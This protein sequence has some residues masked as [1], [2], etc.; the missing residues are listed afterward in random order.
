MTA[1]AAIEVRGLGKRRGGRWVVD[2]VSFTVAAGEVVALA[3]GNGAG[4]TTVLAMIAGVLEP[5]R[6][7]IALAGEPAHRRRRLGYV[8]EAADPPGHLTGAELL[9]LCAALRG[10]PPLDDEAARLLDVAAVAPRR[11]DRMSLG[12]RRRACLAAALIGAPPALVLDE[13]DNGLDAAGLDALATVVAHARERGAGVLVATHDPTIKDRLAG[14]TLL[15]DGG[16]LVDG[17][18]PATDPAPPP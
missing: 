12:Q 16:R 7:W 13:P 17:G 15:L 18:N 9:A 2:D 10:G 3:G 14:R 11:F 5:D 4:K 8:P 1:P 6:G